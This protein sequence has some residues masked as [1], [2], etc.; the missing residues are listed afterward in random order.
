MN[1]SSKGVLLI[2][3]DEPLKRV[4]LQIECSE[5]GYQVHEFSDAAAALQM[6]SQCPV[7]VV[8]TDLRMP[9][10]DGL[11]FLERIK[12]QSPQTHVILMTAY[13]SIDSAVEAIKRGAYDYL[14]KPFRTELLLDKVDRLL[15][16]RRISA[17][18]QSP[19][20]EKI[21]GLIARSAPAR[22]LFERIRTV[23]DNE[24][25]ILVQGESGTG[26]KRVAETIHDLSR[27]KDRPFVR[28]TCNISKAELIAEELCGVSGSGASGHPGVFKRA[29]G[30]T[31]LL[32]H[33]DTL[34]LDLQTKL[35]HMV[36]ENGVTP[37]GKPGHGPQDVRILCSTRNDLRHLVDEGRFREDLYFL[38][39]AVS[40]TIPPLRERR[41]DIPVLADLFI[42]DYV[43]QA[44]GKKGPVRIH[45]HA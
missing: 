45:P 18:A 34:P 32:E 30:G 42:K 26:K 5:A 4:T 38:L 23:A 27:R 36:E 22:R 35:L 44:T 31:L 25:A 29:H 33:V 12:A 24:R 40:L 3:D 16:C 7:D 28:F 10:M 11:R 37:Q 41:E 6:L 8:I 14:A 21:G 39:C 13:G 19:G 9:G 20:V 2:V 15:A 43:A 17:V 1:E